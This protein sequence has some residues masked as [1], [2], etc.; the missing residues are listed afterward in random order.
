MTLAY[1]DPATDSA[2][3]PEQAPASQTP[4][5]AEYA[6]WSTPEVLADLLCRVFPGRIALVSSFG[7]ESAVLLHL[8]SRIDRAAPVI[9]LETGRLFSETLHYRDALV[10]RLGLSDVRSVRPDAGTLASA[11]PAGTPWQS[12]PDL[13]CWHRKVEPLD[14]ALAGFPAS[15]TGRKRFQGGMR[16][17]L[18][19]IEREGDRVKVNALASWSA[20]QLNGYMAEHGLPRHLLDAQGHR[21][22]GCAPCKRLAAPGADP[23]AGRWAGRGKTERGIHLPHVAAPAPRGPALPAIPLSAAP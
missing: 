11:D 10:D 23:R 9:F 4:D 15:I 16:S 3:R 17:A 20:K 21:S 7:I 2:A 22:L 14:E 6:G 13:C 19:L 5:L 18:P 12:D 8:V 1:T